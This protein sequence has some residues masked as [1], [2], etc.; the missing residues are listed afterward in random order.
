MEALIN[1]T[2]LNKSIEKILGCATLALYGED[3]RFSV[4]LA[5]RDVRDYLTNV[6]AGDPAFNQRVFQNSLTALAN[7]THPSMPDYKKTI[8]YAA[9]LMTVELGE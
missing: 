7:S 3:I 5:I 1:D 4:L 2:Y 9:T 6:K 8:E